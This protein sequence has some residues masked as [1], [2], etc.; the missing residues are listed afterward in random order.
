MT[1]IGGQSGLDMLNVSFVGHDPKRK[2]S[3]RE[4]RI[5]QVRAEETSRASDDAG[6]L[7]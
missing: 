4:E 7:S 1:A 3:A 6:G 5:G 2:S